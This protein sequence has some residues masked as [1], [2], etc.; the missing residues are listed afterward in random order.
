MATTL[1]TELRK[2]NINDF[3]RLSKILDESY[4][5]KTVMGKILNDNSEYR[6]LFTNEH[7]Q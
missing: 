4:M 1:D 6:P 3:C 5:W 2:I 7:V